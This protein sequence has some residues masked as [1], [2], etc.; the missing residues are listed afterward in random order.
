MNKDSEDILIKKYNITARRNPDKEE[1]YLSRLLQRREFFILLDNFDNDTTDT[2]NSSKLISNID[3]GLY[4]NLLSSNCIYN[5]RS[6][7]CMNGTI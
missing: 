2:T 3:S 4:R 1:S 7:L 5:L 6:I